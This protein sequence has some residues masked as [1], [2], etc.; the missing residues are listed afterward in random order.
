M[1]HLASPRIVRSA[2]AL[3]IV[4]GTMGAPL[5]AQRSGRFLAREDIVLLGLGLTVTPAH[6]TVPKDIA[7]IVSTF[8]GAANQPGSLP[9]FGPDAVIKGTL[10]GPSLPAPLE[11]SI[12][13]GS[14][15]LFNIPPLS[16]PGIHTLDN[17]RLESGGQTLLFGSPE[18]VTIEVIEKLLVTQ[19]TSR[20]LTA[21]EIRDKGI[22]FDK[23]SF[24][25]YNFTAAFAI[26]DH[27]IVIDF[28]VVLPSLQAPGD[29]AANAAT[30][31]RVDPPGLRSLKTIVPD[32]LRIQTQVPNL[33]VIGFSLT[34]D[35]P[36]GQQ[37]LSFAIP[38][39]VIVPGN[40]GFLN[41]FFS[42]MLMVG[43]VAPA[44]SNLVVT[45]LKADII[46]PRGQDG[47]VGSPDDPLR[48][49]RNE[50][51]ESPRT[52]AI[53]Q[54]GPDGKLGTAD[55][56]ASLA[57]G[58]SGN[59][60]Y[61]VEG[62]R[63]GTHVVEMEISGTLNGLPI[64]PVPVRGRAAGSVLVRN[65]TFTLTFTHPDTVAAGEPYTLDVTVTNT[66]QSPANF[67]SV[68]LFAHNISGATLTG[69]G[70]RDIETIPPGDSATVSFDLVSRITGKVTAATLDD[71]VA[72][73]FALKTAV[74]E[75][76]VPVSPDSLILPA[77]ARTL[78]KPLLEAAV[79]LL[80][81]AWAVATAPAGAL[82]PAVSRM[83]KQ[84]VLDR[85]VEV[86]GAGFRVSLHEPIPDSAAQLAM[87]F[88]GSDFAR[89][90]QLTKPLD[91]PFVT[92]DVLAFDELR[93]TSVRGDVF[94][95]A[96][97]NILRD[98]VATLGVSTFHRGLAE[99]LS[100]RPG[101]MAVLAA[102]DGGLLPVRVTI[103]DAANR[104]LGGADAKG[105]IAKEIPFS[106]YLPFEDGDGARTG[107][108]AI[109][110]APEPGQFIVRLEPVAGAAAAA[111]YTVSVI[112]PDGAGGLR[113]IVYANLTAGSPPAPVSVPGSPFSL[114]FQLAGAG[115]SS[116]PAP[117]SS[118]AAIVNPPP[119]LLG[120]VQQARADML[121]CGPDFP[122]I[123]PGR[124]VAALFSEEVTPESAQDKRAA[125]DVTRYGVDGNAVVGV[126]LQ[127]GRRIAFLAL[128][129]PIGPFIQRQLTVSD[130]QDGAGQS[131]SAQTVAIESTVTKPGGV[132]SGQVLDATGTPVSA[133][134]RLFYYVPCQFGISAMNTDANGRFSWDYVLQDINAAEVL[135]V[136]L[137][138]DE[139]RRVP[140][141]VQRD[142]Q[143][144]TVNVV[145]LG[146][147]TLAGRTL[148]ESG[149]P[150]AGSKLKVTSLTDHS[151]YG[152][153]TDENGRFTIGNIPVG[154]VFVE[155]VN[156]AAHAQ[157]NLS[158]NIPLA[159]GTTVKDV[160]LLD[161][162]TTQVTIKTGALS[163][164]VL[165]S[166]GATPVAGAPVTVFYRHLSQPKVQCPSIEGGNGTDCPI[167]VGKTDDAGRFEFPSITAGA[168]RIETFD[169]ATLQQGEAGVV[170]EPDGIASATVLLGAGLGTVTGAV[171]DSA[172]APIEGARV[173]GGLTLTTTDA[174]GEFVLKDVPVGKREIV[175]VSD[176]LGARGSTTIDLVRDGE[177]VRA[178]IVLDAHGSVAGRIVQADAN[179]P[180]R[181]LKVYLFKACDPPLQGICIIATATTDLDGA[182]RMDNIPLGIYTLSAFNAGLTD[183]NVAAVAVRFKGQVVRT[184]VTFKGGGG[185]VV[186]TVFDDD[187]VTPLK[188]RV[189]ISGER[190]VTAGGLVGTGFRRVTNYAIVESNL[191]TGQFAFDDL[192]VGPFT[193]SAVGQFS[194]DPIGLEGAIPAAGATVTMNLRLQPTSV[195]GGTVFAS[196][197]V[198]SAGANVIVR[199]K[200]DAVRAICTEDAGGV[201]SCKAI[202][203]GIQEEVVATDAQG[204][205]LLPVVNAGPFTI[206]AEDPV[207]GKVA[208]TH[209]TIRAGE[210][211]DIAIRLLGVGELT[212]QVFASDAATPIPGARVQVSQLDFP[213]QK[214]TFLADAQ[215]K[216][217]F[218]GGDAFTEGEV[219]IVA[220]DLRNGFAGRASATLQSDG[221]K[222]AV[223]VFLFNA[224]GRV[225][226]TI[227]QSDGLTP[228]PNT[229]VTLS[230]CVPDLFAGCSSGGPLAFLV[231][232]ANGHY[233][234]EQIPL[235]NFTVEVFDAS[236]ARRGFAPGRI[237]FAGQSVPVNVVEAALG[238]V[239]GHLLAGG[240][241][242][243]LKGG[244]VAL[245]Q[246]SQA[247]R[248]LPTLNGTSS[249]DGSFAFPGTSIGPF[250]IDARVRS[251]EPGGFKQ[252][253]SAIVREGETVDLPIVIDIPRPIYGTIGGRVINPD[254][255]AAVNSRVELC[256]PGIGCGVP[257]LL[258]ADADGRFALAHVPIGRFRASA[259]SQITTDTGS[260]DA[261]LVFEGET[262]DVTIVLGGLRQV[263]GTV[264]AFDTN[265]PVPNV[266]VVLSGLPSSGCSNG[267]TTFTDAGGQFSF[268]DV[269]AETFT[270]TARNPLNGLKGATGGSLNPGEHKIVRVVLQATASVSGRVLFA[271]GQP[272]PRIIAEL[273]LLEPG[274]GVRESLFSETAVDGTF[275]FPTAAV[276]PYR[277]ELQDAIGPG[278]GRRLGTASG[279]EQLGDIVLD[280]QPPA[281]ASTTPAP[282]ATGV[283]QDQTIQILFSEPIDRGTIVGANISLTDGTA[284]V[285]ALLSVATGDASVALT[286]LSPLQT[287]RRYSMR[288]HGVK[289]RLGK[290]MTA[291]Y[292]LT[293]TTIDIKAPEVVAISPGAGAGGVPIESTIRIAF[294]EPFDPTRLR[295]PPLTVSASSGPIAGRLDLLF[296]NTV[297]AF[298]PLLPL[299]RGASYRVLVPAVTDLAGNPQA[300]DLDYA[301]STTDGSAPE[302]AGLVA[303]NNGTVIE[304]SASTVTANTGTTHD[305]AVVDF[306]LNDIIA[307]SD[308]TAPFEL[309]FQALAA[310]G[311]VGSQIKVSALATDTSGN[312]GHLPAV[313]FVTVTAD[314][315]PAV[316]ILAPGNGTA[317]K[318][319]DRI[320]VPVRTVDDL[321]VANIGYRAQTGKPQDAATRL[322][323]PAATD[324]TESFVFFV[325]EDAAPGATIRIEASAVDTKGQ[326]SQ[327][328]PV[329]LTVLDAVPPVVTITGLASGAKLRPGQQATAVVSAQDLGG[330]ASITFRSSGA[331]AFEQT[332]TIDP[333][334]PSVAASYS[335]TILAS[336]RPGDV[337]NLDATAVDKAGNSTAAA[338]LI[339]PILDE[340]PPTIHL[341]T[342][343][344]S[345]DL[346]PGSQVTVI[347]D[348]ED[349]IGVTRVDL[350]GEGA[351]TLTD[352]KQITPPLGSAQASFTVNVPAALAE[353]SVLNLRATATDISNNVS[354]PATLSLTVRSVATVSLPPSVIVIA[355]DSV[356][357]AI[358][359][360][361][362]APAG[363][364]TVTFASRNQDVAQPEASVHFEDGETAG[365]LRIAGLSGGITTID[366]SIAGVQR[367]SMTATV[368]GGI[369]T[370]RVLDQLLNPVAGAQV[371]IVDAFGDPLAATTD[372]A[373]EYFIEGV[374]RGFSFVGFT[375][376]ALNPVNGHIAAQFGQ[377]SQAGGFA[378]QNLV[379]IAAGSVHGVVFQADGQTR[380]GTGVIVRILSPNS[381]DPL[382]TT[383]TNDAGEYEFPLVTLGSYVVEATAAGNKG[384]AS[385][386]LLNSGDTLEVPITFLGRGTVVGKVLDGGS[387][388]VGNAEL[389]FTTRTVFGQSAPTTLNAQPDGTY[390]FENVP[391]GE[392]QIEARDAV[393]GAAGSV[394]GRVDSHL[395]EVRK[396]VVVAA[397]GT[398]TGTVYRS[399]GVTPVPNADV[400]TG[401]FGAL[402]TQTDDQGHYRFDFL[403]L[404]TTRVDVSDR[405]TG[406]RGF[407]VANLTTNGQTVVLDVQ[408]AG[409]GNIRAT[410]VDALGH[411]VTG[412][413]VEIRTAN[414]LS[415]GE[416]LY[417]LTGTDGTALIEHVLV[418]PFRALAWSR[419]L[420]AIAD[421]TLADN[422]L[423]QVTLRL[424]PTGAIAGIVYEPDGQTPAASGVVYVHDGGD[425]TFAPYFPIATATLNGDG[426]FSIDNLPLRGYNLSVRDG[427][428]RL[429]AVAKDI[430]L[431]S[432]GQI[433]TRNPTLIGLG[434]VNGRVLNPDS[435]SAPNLDV[436]V[437]SRTQYFGTTTTV[438]TNAAGFYQAQDV[439]AGGFTVS[440]GDAS[441]QL[442]GEGSGQ[443][444]HH[445]ETVTVDVLLQNNAVTLPVTKFDGN[446]QYFPVR[447]DGAISGN[448]GDLFSREFQGSQGGMLLD[449]VVNGSANRFTGAAIGTVEE[450]GREVVTRQ[451]GLGGLNVTRKV[452][453]P[454][455]GYFGRY[456]EIL[457][458]PT[459]AP[460]TVG[461][462]L[463]SVLPRY[464]GSDFYRLVAS[465]SGDNLLD[466]SSTTA[467]DRWVVFDDDAS[468]SAATAF[469]FDGPEGVQ[470][471]GTAT[472]QPN[473]DP[474]CQFIS[475][476]G[477]YSQ[478]L[479]YEWTGVT[480]EPGASVAYVH[481][482]V[483]QKTQI[484]AIAS[485]QRLVQLPPEALAGLSASELDAIRNFAMPPGGNSVVAA[486]PPVTAT[487]SGTVFEGDGVT[488]V[489][490][491]IQAV[492]FASASPFYDPDLR[493]NSDASGHFTISGSLSENGNSML[494]P[495]DG[496]TLV[497]RHPATN[498]FS[499][500][501][502]GAFAA[503][504]VTTTQNVVFTNLAVAKGVVRRHTGVVV[505]S[506]FLTVS[507]PG[508]FVQSLPVAADGSY[509]AGGLA[510]GAVTVTATLAHPQGSP[511]TG[512][513][514]LETTPGQAIT[515]D[516]VF[517]PTGSL[518]G[519]VR[520]ATNAVAP[521]VTVRI[522]QL[523]QPGFIRST[524]TDTSGTYLLADAPAAGYRVE[525]IDPVTTVATRTDVTIAQDQTTV[526]NLQLVGSGTVQV[527]VAFAGGVPAPNVFVLIVD[528][529]GVQRSFTTNAAGRATIGNVPV[530]AFSVDA[531][532]PLLL[533]AKSSA[534]G[535]LAANGDTV[536]VSVTLPALGSVR[537]QVTFAGGAPAAGA[538]V[539][540][541]VAGSPF[542]QG[543]GNTNAAGQLT[544]DN[545]V[546]GTE[547]VRVHHPLSPGTTVESSGALTTE[548]QLVTIAVSLPAVG[549]IQLQVNSLSGAPVSGAQV[550]VRDA[551]D[552]SQRPAGT[553]DVN[554]RLTIGLVRGV[555][556][557]QASD[558][559]NQRFNRHAGGIVQIE[560][561]VVPIT[562][563]LG[564]RGTVSGTVFNDRG[565][566]IGNVSVSLISEN[567]FL[568]FNQ[569]SAADGSYSVADVP[570]GR[571][572]VKATTFGAAAGS[573][574]GAVAQHGDAVVADVHMTE[575]L[576]GTRLN[577]ANE[578][579]YDVAQFGSVSGGLIAGAQQLSVGPANDLQ[580]FAGDFI[581]AAE[582]GGRQLAIVNTT[583]SD[584]GFPAPLAGLTATR[585]VYVPPAGYFVRFLDV[586]ENPGPAPV[587]VNVRLTGFLVETFGLQTAATS[588]GDQML[589]TADRWLIARD[590]F[591]TSLPAAAFVFQGAGAAQA[592]A[593]PTTEVLPMRPFVGWKAVRIE[594][595]SRAIFM[596]FVLQHT[597]LAAA[598]AASERLA[599][600]PPEALAGIA[601]SDLSSIRNFAVPPDG[602]S[603]VPPFGTV[604]GRVLTG[605]ST[606]VPNALV[607]IGGSSAPI[608]KPVISVPADA[609]GRYSASTLD[610]GPFTV[611]AKDP[612]LG[613]VTALASLTLAAGQTSVTQDLVFDGSGT[614]RGIV[615][616]A[617]GAAVTGGQ[618]RITGGT[619]PLDI[620]V[621][622]AS[623]GTYAVNVL[624]PGTYNVNASVADRFGTAAGRVVVAGA[625]TVADI[626]LR[627]LATVRIT[628]NNSA[629]SPLPGVTLILTDNVFF[630][631]QVVTDA[632]GA[633]VFVSVPDGTF[634]VQA[635]S[636]SLLGTFQGT[637]RPAD[638]GKTLDF[639]F[640][641]AT[642]TISGTV[643]LGNGTPAA[644]GLVQISPDGFNTVA[645]ASIAANGTYQVS[646][647]PGSYKVFATV[648]GQVISSAFFSVTTGQQVVVDLK[649]P[650]FATVRLTARRLDGSAYAGLQATIDDSAGSRSAGA[651]DLA[652]QLQIPGV[653]EGAFTVT[654]SNKNSSLPVGTVSGQVAAADDGRIVDVV[655]ES[656][657]GTIRG[658]VFA[659]DGVTALPQIYLELYDG[660]SGPFLGFPAQWDPKLGIHVT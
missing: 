164:H 637:V 170:L 545:V 636:G 9:P 223:K 123:F 529:G 165:R 616:R 207:T 238:L 226:G 422:E 154:N 493:V 442:L 485:A 363:G 81:K 596:H 408:L 130:V 658:H 77:E 568:T 627:A 218:L 250:S 306:Y 535:V 252:V 460:I 404:R 152:T 104:Q 322:V 98:Q 260:V 44:G 208:Q 185:H 565:L 253:E 439:A 295:A 541:S 436:E 204:R 36:V 27:P 617:S 194:P 501:V 526:Q 144:L 456:L 584:G 542:F 447:A 101:H 213:K 328:A 145:L 186:G 221:Q 470:R 366:A 482:L 214:R 387:Q 371:T 639:S 60:E 358:Q 544:I 78:P 656:T 419:G 169:Q 512:V 107:E 135:A 26:Q 631:P 304:G 417:E 410:V 116:S 237:D 455:T 247:G 411:P 367:A 339:L 621:P 283:P 190:I 280:E 105:K 502:T 580:L 474:N 380:T 232:D 310:L 441:R 96:V 329:E 515:R 189:A 57:P 495:A 414:P 112:L 4:L 388:P 84:V 613:S 344:G 578:F 483:Q 400:S 47:V 480:I 445:G 262:S 479:V 591:Q 586:L 510:A 644:S 231:A 311:G 5:Q 171:L 433:E 10:R 183:G 296:G 345:L 122:P 610:Q 20:P 326:V 475:F 273:V 17:I 347:A 94:A 42:V 21:A 288:V 30:V 158:E 316:T 534:A 141:T 335:F 379:V 518:T 261:E 576:L 632:A 119:R 287:E 131:M 240:T 24:Q 251:P 459:A 263:S 598:Q 472:V 293:F 85:A 393:T 504:T 97:G 623:D 153:T 216:I 323:S 211:A 635:Y 271:N 373:G 266:E 386:A 120:V 3:L 203:Q 549:S 458:N 297:M 403:P 285:P 87:D 257:L 487:I 349:E 206:T 521:N 392:F 317:V 279:A 11:L 537:V 192:L 86:A 465:S 348:V 155:A 507:G 281:V 490:S 642:S 225:S 52:R 229:E 383:F 115:G 399:D 424:Q 595:G 511:L 645:S 132:V 360:A 457:S 140:F 604:S 517:P 332:R 334:L 350:S 40:I 117:A 163:G 530:G 256:H 503:D 538:P 137:D 331:T 428:G 43:N 62:R 201:A 593:E 12:S 243:P 618:V 58:D 72:G 88:M 558:P 187:G 282:G 552:T 121:Q 41:Q 276:G 590:T 657:A 220:T 32:T 128:R 612:V 205:Y 374:N 19:V 109:V 469:V 268:V 448:G 625:T 102:G 259:R 430:V 294:S 648:L 106:D 513:T 230:N 69:E 193:L 569:L 491:T 571:F 435:S 168:L 603:S 516:L 478:K 375:I 607:T 212:V 575:V 640:A 15:A 129:D 337:V 157:V 389:R 114:V 461:V 398:L 643:R 76:G 609:D 91:L 592:L 641:V 181:F 525:A 219:V 505:P 401:S 16:V 13:P 289:D 264:Y 376:K 233:D 215:G 146:R 224:T 228:A 150:L 554:G 103:L 346:T 133:N 200:S 423:R 248:A 18:T 342:S 611:Q 336:A 352:A 53:V 239:T 188:A 608:F 498:L 143:R 473:P 556:D 275:T 652:G 396:D 278:I 37:L 361:S 605:A 353:G 29:V 274:G 314:Q 562:I 222:L 124:I 265:Q 245:M 305:I 93:R 277:L 579:R 156:V 496:F 499:P 563:V 267:C 302:L 444:S 451:Q 564:T 160:V 420:I 524:V 378:R 249:V 489:R 390:R 65:P 357:A 522:S 497:A 180:A 111:T 126:A 149:A 39:V 412:A 151:Q 178:T 173:G 523:A 508:F 269:P 138:G 557:V 402:F 307:G 241:L 446:N 70:S 519:V 384:R 555:F 319:G 365:V 298:T 532:H 309:S 651:T 660:G 583:R 527:D 464:A 61:L 626:D 136:K 654:L 64:G 585:K 356:D 486:L 244:E 397:Y 315:P 125:I 28:P 572:R 463:S 284:V 573:A 48:M 567:P 327:A 359:L 587:T 14:T 372:G 543:Y 634:T 421:D 176:A 148:S 553:T 45:D 67:V 196:N 638:D 195:I 49:A 255:T 343:T 51:G 31:P 351:F 650:A 272:A 602:A 246:R 462:R 299:A 325:P 362:P 536:P 624:T 8:L 167:A 369:V 546:G 100:Y 209:G 184:D 418:G 431:A 83:S 500:A 330:I 509:F 615:R 594:P 174:S 566:P 71:N 113:Q 539:E 588:S 440:T 434:S 38:G 199:F 290:A 242:A 561:A 354:P 303:S 50:S 533:S 655:F 301:F 127:P 25:A 161:V 92:A 364:L 437:R 531:R 142:G 110:A 453:V 368:R 484:R 300:A 633:A 338:R 574:Y 79:G 147:G 647:V 82:P 308:R 416:L 370:G 236:T 166:N 34:L 630:R 426:V 33:S 68:N 55:D 321:G 313:T 450:A 614:L 46:L 415:S 413:I 7:T 90:A 492:R 560:G 291:D 198:T 425:F 292:V 452:F 254:G 395:Q 234:Q 540:M 320:V 202:P 597:D 23:S 477:C 429:R 394:S 600:M 159:G 258:T 649:Y 381:P 622:I 22:V 227:F 172:G 471:A 341:R 182:Y 659:G 197:G 547:T 581:A 63:E 488:P 324:R 191:S 409:Q 210:T 506:G 385:L 382:G 620:T 589:T 99:K 340:T 407:A 582:L 217:T 514:Q 286:P 162:D 476:S 559:A 54:L 118:N 629:G 74:G 270:V 466:V 432:P 80:G 570:T 481:F 108:L 427:Q 2:V 494:V 646:V 56:I 520:T 548:G 577:D 95:R 333:A 449:L 75:L 551:S 312:R 599:Q 606:P 550:L 406:G 1:T 318:N 438:R 175:A 66:S 601:P 467:P 619:P 653:R 443:I 235:G 377:L 628:L 73:R 405:G 355:G 134:V 179:T 6:Q 139:A 528:S 454:L 468:G 35:L 177:T 89:L 59:A 391:V